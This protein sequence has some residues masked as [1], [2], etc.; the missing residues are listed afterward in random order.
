MKNISPRQL[1]IVILVNLTFGC[2]VQDPVLPKDDTN[3]LNWEEM[4]NFPGCIRIEAA[5]FWI[6]EKFY[7]GLGFGYVGDNFQT[8]DNLNDFYEYDTFSKTWTKKADFPGV[9]RMKAA[10]FSIGEKGY[11]GFGQS[12]VN[13]DQGCE[14]I[15]YK[16]IWEYDPISDTW[17][18]AGTF[19]QVE[20]GSTTYAKSYPINDKVYITLG[21][22]L[23][24]FNPSGKS[25]EKIGLMP[26]GMILTSGFEINNKIYLGTG[27]TP[28]I[29]SLFY[30]FDPATLTWSKKA[31]FPGP[32]RRFASGFTYNGKG[33]LTCG[34]GVLELS[35][36]SYQFIGLKDTWEYDPGMDSWTMINDYPGAAFIHQACS[37]SAS[38]AAIGT[39]ETGKDI[40]YGKDF[41]IVR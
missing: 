34:Q 27:G 3:K 26:E 24:V 40:Y 29:V 20:D 10:S 14:Q 4:K 22:D 28:E 7:V 31:D 33:Y 6:G 12:M 35:P 30:E 16:D 15:S 39:G 5:S 2:K 37:N 41:W 38:K 23:W 32:K 17:G 8:L 11:V 19:D 25:L 1:I 21:Y 36:G 9:G 13:C 18:E